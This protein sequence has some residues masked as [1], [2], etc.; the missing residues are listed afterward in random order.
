[1]D[2]AVDCGERHGLIRED[3][4]PFAERLVGGD[5]QRAALVARGDQFEQHAGFGL[6]LGHIGDVV[7]DEQVVAIELRD[8]RF[9]GEFAARDLQALN[10][11][12]RSHE[13]DAPAGFDQGKADR[14]RQMALAPA[15]W[16]EQQ[17]I[18]AGVEPDVPCGQRHRLRFR[19][20]GHALEVERGERFAGGQPSL[21]QMPLDAPA[22]AV[23]G[24]V[25]GERGEEAGGRPALLVGLGG[26]L[27]PDRLDARQTKLAE[28]ELDARRVDGSRG[29]AHAAAPAFALGPTATQTSSS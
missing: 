5:E 6:I 22:R 14:G 12:R 10:E 26:D 11:I 16:T 8:S 21:G 4:P 3:A 24:L 1:M 17:Q 23:G 18:G 27:R 29:A 28:Q 20:H 9:E 15:G 13:Q 19:H 2:E 25:L 7:E